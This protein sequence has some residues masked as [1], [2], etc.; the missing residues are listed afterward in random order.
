[1]TSSGLD[2]FLPAV[3]AVGPLLLNVDSALIIHRWLLSDWDIEPSM[4]QYR[5]RGIYL[6]TTID[7]TDSMLSWQGVPP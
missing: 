6:H 2:K 1:M 4:S 5:H 3:W 7:G